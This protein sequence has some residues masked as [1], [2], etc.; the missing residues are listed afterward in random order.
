MSNNSSSENND[1]I[2]M[3]YIMYLMLKDDEQADSYKKSSEFTQDSNPTSLRKIYNTNGGGLI[4]YYIPN[5]ESLSESD[6][7]L[8]EQYQIFF[9][10]SPMLYYFIPIVTYML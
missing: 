1:N 6:L 2:G 8:L 7:K 9:S 10:L 3:P 4:S 5:P